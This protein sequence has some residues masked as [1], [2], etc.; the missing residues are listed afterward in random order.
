[1]SLLADGVLKQDTAATIVQLEHRLRK[2]E[3]LVKKERRRRLIL[4]KQL[5][6]SPGNSLIEGNVT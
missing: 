5:A 2:L 3:K 6:E 4:E 1:M